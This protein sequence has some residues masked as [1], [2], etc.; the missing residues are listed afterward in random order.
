MCIRDR[1]CDD[2][3][4]LSVE[5]GDVDDLARVLGF[6]VARYG[7]VVAVLGEGAVADELGEVGLVA[8]RGEGVQDLSLIHI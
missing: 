8:T 4:D 6:D 7:D 5:G 2:A 1:F 3:G